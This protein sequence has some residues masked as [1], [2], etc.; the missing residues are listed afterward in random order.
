MTRASELLPLPKSP[1][2]PTTSPRRSL[3]LTSR[4]LWT[5][6]AC[7]ELDQDLA[8]LPILSSHVSKIADPPANDVRDDRL[9]RQLGASAQ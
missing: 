7:F 8:G 5:P 4:G 9:E 3:R 1:A 6:D 2:M